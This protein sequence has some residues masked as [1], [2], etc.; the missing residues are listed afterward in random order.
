VAIV[1]SIASGTHFCQRCIFAR[2][3]NRAMSTLFVTND[4]DF[5]ECARNPVHTPRDLTDR[6]WPLPGRRMSS[7]DAKLHRSKLR[8]MKPNSK[9]RQGIYF[10]ALRNPWFIANKSSQIRTQS[11]RQ[12]L[13]ER[14]Q[15]NAPIRVPTSKG[16]RLDAEPRRSFPCPPNRPHAPARCSHG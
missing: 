14:R 15:H 8:L 7:G 3:S 4:R 12:R 1:R 6:K 10:D 16:V 2:I 9:R 11:V 13:G 5:A